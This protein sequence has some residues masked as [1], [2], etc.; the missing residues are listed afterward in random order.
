M[1]K[2]TASPWANSARAPDKSFAEKQDAVLYA[3]AQLFCEKG[4]HGASFD[5]LA[6][7]LMISKP[8]IYYYVT[9]K[10]ECL[11][12]ISRRGQQAAIDAIRQSE[13]MNSTAL[14]KLMFVMR[15][16]ATVLTTDFGRCLSLVGRS[17]LHGP[18]SKEI[19]ARA[20]W[21]DRRIFLLFEEGIAE[22][23]IRANDPTIAHFAT[24]GAMNWIARWY[25]PG[26]RIGPEA[27]VEGQI[28]FL[29]HGLAPA[30]AA[31]ENSSLKRRKSGKN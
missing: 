11:L 5:E 24:I 2:N 23:S 15:R 3:A 10:A 14:E 8:T 21:A 22:G 26:G 9:S 31:S 1:K 30:T 18:A 12:E 29:L 4:F 6:A 17:A 28:R 7:R 13:S 16:Y 25:K 19:E 20:K 27:L